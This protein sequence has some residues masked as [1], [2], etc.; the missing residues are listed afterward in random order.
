MLSKDQKAEM[1]ESIISPDAFGPKDDEVIFMRA[2]HALQRD[3]YS[4]D[5]IAEW[6]YSHFGQRGRTW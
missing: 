3:E 4:A 2:L 6:L 5:D 1:D